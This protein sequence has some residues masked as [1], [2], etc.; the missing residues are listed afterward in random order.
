[1]GSSDKPWASKGKG[2]KLYNLNAARA[3]ALPSKSCGHGGGKSCHIHSETA[4]ETQRDNYG[5]CFCCCPLICLQ[6]PTLAEH[7]EKPKGTQEP[8]RG[9]PVLAIL[10][11]WGIER[12]T[13]KL[14]G[15]QLTMTCT[16][17]VLHQHPGHIVCL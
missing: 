4:V 2:R 6:A 7:S 10:P 12:Q 3:G 8:V 15:D 11:A 14:D 16:E 17:C 1:M 5:G 9:S 13:M